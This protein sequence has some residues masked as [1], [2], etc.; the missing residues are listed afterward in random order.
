MFTK[1]L[2]GVDGHQGGRDAI[3]LAKQLGGPEAGIALARV[4]GAGLMPGAG[5]AMLLAVEVEEAEALLERERAT[6]APGAELITC[7]DHSVGRGLHRLAGEHGADL[8]VIG[9][10]RHG[11]AGRVLL[12]NVAVATLAGAPCA[13]AIAPPGY[14]LEP[15]LLSRLGVGFDG[16]PE[17]RRALAVARALAARDGSTVDALRILPLQSRPYGEPA[18]NRWPDIAQEAPEDVD[19]EIGYGRPGEEL[20]RFSETLDLLIVGSRDRGSLRRM[21]AGSTSDHL[22]RRAHCPLL[23]L[24]G[25]AS[26]GPD[27]QSDLVSTATNREGPCS[28]TS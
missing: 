17:A 18:G 23:V 4:Y 15:H 7:A 20:E 9:A 16:S 11:F 27:R 8:I 3:A 22:A 26:G 10:C 25:R 21:L 13:V 5:A 24:P 28:T 6:A 2:V 1:V 19:G 14:A 12:G